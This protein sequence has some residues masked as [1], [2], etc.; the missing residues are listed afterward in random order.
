MACHQQN[1][2]VG[3]IIQTR[4]VEGALWFEQCQGDGGVGIIGRGTFHQLGLL[5]RE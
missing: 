5:A 4:G 3:G 2:Q 1:A